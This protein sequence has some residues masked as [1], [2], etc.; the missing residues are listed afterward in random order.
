MTSHNG[1]ELLPAATRRTPA[2]IAAKQRKREDRSTHRQ[3]VEAT[4]KE[5]GRGMGIFD[6][7]IATVYTRGKRVTYINGALWVMLAV[8]LWWMR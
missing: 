3:R 5:V 7:A 1:H 8:Y 6:A 2:R 4:F